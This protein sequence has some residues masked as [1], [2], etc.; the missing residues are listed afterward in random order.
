MKRAIHDLLNAVYIMYEPNI[1]NKYLTR[2][3]D[4]CLPLRVFQ[5]FSL[6]LEN[7]VAGMHVMCFTWNREP[8]DLFCSDSFCRLTSPC[9]TLK[10][11][12]AMFYDALKEENQIFTSCRDFQENIFDSVGSGKRSVNGSLSGVFRCADCTPRKGM[13]ERTTRLDV[14]CSSSRFKCIQRQLRN[15]QMHKT[16]LGTF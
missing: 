2:G 15:S 12:S 8:V 16:K 3:F 9:G 14:Y 1:I 11:F 4:F 13:T 5:L 7:F 6:Y 10:S